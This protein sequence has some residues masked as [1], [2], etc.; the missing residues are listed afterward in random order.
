MEAVVVSGAA[1]SDVEAMP[2]ALLPKALL[3]CKTHILMS[4]V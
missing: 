1:Y 4:R 2:K 3:P